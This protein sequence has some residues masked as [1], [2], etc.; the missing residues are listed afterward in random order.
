MSEASLETKRYL[1]NIGSR[2]NAYFNTMNRAKEYVLENGV[3]DHVVVLNCVIMSLLW[4][5][6]VRE[7]VLTEEEMFMFLNI[8]TNLADAKVIGIA[9]TMKDWPLEDVLSYVVDNF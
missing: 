1:E 3:Y 7:E 5:A 9:E 2:I 6:A 4:L 8:E